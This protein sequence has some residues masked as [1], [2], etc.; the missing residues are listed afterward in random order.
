MT[1]GVHLEQGR[2]VDAR[3]PPSH[4]LEIVL[5]ERP[6]DMRRL[7]LVIATLATIGCGSDDSSS[8]T[9]PGEKY[10]GI[11]PAAQC[12]PGTRPRIGQTECVPVGPTGCAGG[13]RPA[14]SGWGCEAMTAPSCTG[15][16][17]AV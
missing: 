6:G 2:P 12:A 8:Q 13:F 11:V 14:S 16:D 10:S 4:L 17:R 9:P 5:R 15:F 3:V 7:A 1:A